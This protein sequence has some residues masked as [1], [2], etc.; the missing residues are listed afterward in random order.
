M[1]NSIPGMQDACETDTPL[2]KSPITV[3]GQLLVSHV[4]FFLFSF[5]IQYKHREWN[6]LAIKNGSLPLNQDNFLR[7]NEREIFQTNSF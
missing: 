2:T 4:H 1:T 5:Q 3:L 6:L 7:N